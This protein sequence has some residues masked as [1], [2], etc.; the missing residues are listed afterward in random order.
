MSSFIDAVNQIL[1]RD[2]KIRGD[3]DPLT[4]FS[5]T[6]LNASSQLAQISIQD[7]I[8]NL[9]SLGLLAYQHKTS[10]ITLVTGTRSYGLP[11]D[12][13]RFFGDPPFL[14]DATQNIEIYAY[15]GGENSLR[16]KIFDYLTTTGTPIYWY[17][18]QT[19]SKKISVFYTPSSDYNGR[20]WNLDY[21][22]DVNVTNS[23][24]TMPFQNADEFNTFCGMAAI[25]FHIM[26]IQKSSDIQNDLDKN[27][28]YKAYRGTLF[29][30]MRGKKASSRYGS[31]YI[32]P[33]A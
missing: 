5:D 1:R 32:S 4:T 31:A 17:L 16:L 20:V 30:L 29:N 14:Y 10:T 11:S 27:P 7:E 6:T 9:V 15:P 24:D 28:T 33:A 12:F 22:A 19:T 8:S 13:I 25:R 2:G 23:T 21:Y 26:Y 3:N 18:E